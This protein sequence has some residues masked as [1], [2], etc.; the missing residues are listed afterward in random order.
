MLEIQNRKSS[1]DYEI[2]ET[3]EAGIVLTGLEIKAIRAKRV[4][5]ASSYVKILDGE[6][7]W[8]GGII[9]V[10]TGDIQRTRK[11]LLHKNE[12]N[13]LSGRVGEQGLTLVVTRLIIR[14]GKAKL[15]IGLGRGRKKHDKRELLKKR[16][17]ERELSQQG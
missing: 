6:A 14:R 17:I 4:S 2:L 12:L 16:D 11:L 1:F 9:E 10:V 15:E 3:V 5:L 8:L 13:R 7:W